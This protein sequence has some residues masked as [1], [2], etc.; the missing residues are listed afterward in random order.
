MSHQVH[1]SMSRIRNLTTLVITGTVVNPTTIRLQPGRP[2]ILQ[3]K[4][5][6]FLCK[7]SVK[8]PKG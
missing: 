2:L 8:L 1:N 5:K 6:Q 4:R 3:S 7:N